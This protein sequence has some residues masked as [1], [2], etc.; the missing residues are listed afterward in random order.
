MKET[1]RLNVI[2]AVLAFLLKATKNYVLSVHEGKKPYKC[3]VCDSSYYSQ[4]N[5]LRRHIDA[6]HVSFVRILSVIDTR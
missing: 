5:T 1:N 4:P 6:V 3:E 2:F